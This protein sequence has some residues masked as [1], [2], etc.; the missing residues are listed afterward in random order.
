MGKSK[1]SPDIGPVSNAEAFKEA[2]HRKRFAHR[3]SLVFKNR[4]GQWFCLRYR[5]DAIKQAMLAVGTRG[6]MYVIGEGHPAKV[7]WRQA[8]VRLRN[9][10]YIQAL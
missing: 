3:Q 6:F 10:D 4:D 7:G 5:R 1:S 9:V 8:C 2:E